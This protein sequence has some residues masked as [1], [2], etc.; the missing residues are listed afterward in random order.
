M[1]NFTVQSNYDFR[2][3]LS[4]VSNSLWNVA[5]LNAPYWSGNLRS[6]IQRVNNE[7]NNIVFKYNTNNA[8]YLHYLEQ[9]IGPIK[10]HKGFIE[11]KTVM[12]MVQELIGFL[13]TEMYLWTNVS[14]FDIPTV[15]S[16]LAT[17]MFYERNMMRKAGIDP[18]LGTLNAQ[19]RATLALYQNVKRGRK[20][21]FDPMAE[22]VSVRG[23]VTNRFGDPR[24]VGIKKRASV[25]EKISR[26]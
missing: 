24:V 10:K 8:F 25:V 19:E 4:R 26:W 17:P 2:G 1:A 6:Q 3:D 13:S 15:T 11:H 18:K 16:S 21:M 20:M 9:G 22:R 5:V 14:F 23:D 7:S 12:S